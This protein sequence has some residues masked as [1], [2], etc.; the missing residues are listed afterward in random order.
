[1]PRSIPTP[2]DPSPATPSPRVRRLY[3]GHA[4]ILTLAE[5]ARLVPCRDADVRRVLRE[6][7]AVGTFDGSPVVVWIDALARVAYPDGSNGADRMFAALARATGADR[8]I[9]PTPANSPGPLG[10][11]A[12]GFTFRPSGVL[13]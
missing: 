8:L 4:A 10:P 12:P 9:V 3:L 13:S 7:G 5:A 1:M 11:P 6:A 2:R